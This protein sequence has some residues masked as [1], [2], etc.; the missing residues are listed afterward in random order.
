MGVTV[1]LEGAR[2]AARLVEFDLKIDDPLCEMS[3]TG[4]GVP[5]IVWM[6]RELQTAAFDNKPDKAMRWLGYIQGYLVALNLFHVDDM[7]K[8]NMDCGDG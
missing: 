1:N 7:K 8:I 5:H 6:I 4:K 2:K 3:Q